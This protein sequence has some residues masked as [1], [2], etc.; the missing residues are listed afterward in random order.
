MLEKKYKVV[1]EHKRSTNIA[2]KTARL[3]RGYKP[4]PGYLYIIDAEENMSNIFGITDCAFL[5]INKTPQFIKGSEIKADFALLEGNFEKN[6][7]L[8]EIF[9]IIQD[10][11]NWDCMLKDALNDNIPIS[12]FF[13]LGQRII[14]RTY[15]LIDRNFDVIAYS[16]DYPKYLKKYVDL[17]DDEIILRLPSVQAN[18]LLLDKEYHSAEKHKELFIYPSYPCEERFICI[19]VFSGTKFLARMI[20]PLKDENSLDEGDTYLF[21]HFANY[22]RVIYL[23]Y[24]DDFLVRHQNDSLHMLFRTLLFNAHEIDRKK[25]ENILNIY[26]WKN[27]HEYSIVKL[28]FIEG[29]RWEINVNYICQQVEKEWL[30]SCAIRSDDCIIWIVNHR[31]NKINYLDDM[32]FKSLVYIIRE[33]VCKAGISDSFNDF[34]N[35]TPFYSQAEVALA[36]GQERDSHFWYYRF[37]DYICDY[38]FEHLTGNFTSEQLCHKG[39]SVLKKYDEKNGTEYSNTLYHYIVCK[40]NITHAAQ[41]LYVHR[42]T[43]IRRMERIKEI[44]GIDIDN[45]DEILYLM[46]SFKLMGNNNI[47]LN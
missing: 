4:E 35:L 22:V 21:Q 26:G 25:T 45:S 10:L 43:F 12:D 11:Q 40:F 15:M 34:Y 44:S 38:M 36:F 16:S 31:L 47:N 20:S 17:E 2:F 32:F 5:I 3:Y 6:D 41:K 46:I 19:N 14:S 42:T 30:H 1:L 33:Y 39:L 7:L 18:E 29:A 28:Q 9:E 13:L 27:N 24:T 37:N 8:N 23:K